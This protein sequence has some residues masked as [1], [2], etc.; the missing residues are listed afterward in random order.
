[1]VQHAEGAFE[2]D[3]EAV[4]NAEFSH[5]FRGYSID[6]VRSFLEDVGRELHRLKNELAAARSVQQVVAATT[7]TPLGLSDEAHNHATTSVGPG[8]VIDLQSHRLTLERDENFTDLDPEF[9]DDHHSDDHGLAET[10]ER[11]E[12]D[13]QQRQVVPFPSAAPPQRR[14]V[15]DLSLIHI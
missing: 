15:I 12:K 14:A 6:E 2:I 4:V 5:V 1:M 11:S 3:P 9:S 8:T 13:S 10:E 7:E